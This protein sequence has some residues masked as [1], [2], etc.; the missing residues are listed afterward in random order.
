MKD[1][2][3]PIV[4]FKGKRYVGKTG[5]THADIIRANNLVTGGE[6]QR[7]FTSS[8]NGSFMTR[9]QAEQ[10]MQAHEPGVYRRWTGNVGKD[11]RLHSEDYATAVN[12]SITGDLK[13]KKVIVWDHG[14]FTEN[15]LRLLRDCAEVKYF[16]PCFDAFPEPFKAKIG[17]NIDGMERIHYFFDHLENADFIFVP[18]T[19]CFDIVEWLKKH[20]Y[21]C[22][23]AGASELLENDRWHGRKVQEK[24]G[25]PVQLTIKIKGIAQFRDFA[26]HPE[27]YVEGNVPKEWYIKL[28]TF[29]GIEESFKLIDY[30]DIES[31]IDSISYKL[32][33]Y[34]EDVVF[35]CEELISGIEPGTDAVTWEGDTMYPSTVGYEE[36]GVGYLCRVYQKESDMPPT[37]VAVNSVYNSE[38]KKNKTRFFYSTECI[39]DKNGIPFIIDPTIRNAAPGVAA[40][41]C[42]LIENY[43]HVIYGLA[44]GQ[45]IDPI[46]NHKYAAALAM[47][48]ANAQKQWTNISFPKD[49]RQW[50]KLRMAAK[51][52]SDYY[53]VPG[54]DSV[55]TAI[56]FGNTIQEA[57]DTV[58]ERAKMV[59]GKGLSKP[60]KE[61][62]ELAENIQE[63]KRRGINF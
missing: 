20:E 16:C 61:L 8:E 62:E 3:K 34:K 7:G 33:P 32:G 6:A 12:K 44:T 47:E 4:I 21:P 42:E 56:G 50:V 40:I 60:T 35:I 63:G 53:A 19:Y 13:N 45:R 59:K 57:I 49:M 46:M 31:T 15:A 54:F 25:L 29:R 28:D 36:K 43:S 51:K 52:G 9:E 26:Q 10:W 27:K 48:N 24:A 55:C 2:L 11:K 1:H 22:A 14:L 5:D 39:V 23:G 30:K 18:D 37:M 38:F 17:E 41:Q 58:K